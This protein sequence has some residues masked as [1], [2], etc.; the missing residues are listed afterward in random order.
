MNLKRK[1]LEE[2]KP[3]KFLKQSDMTLE[4]SHTISQFSF[5]DDDCIPSLDVSICTV[6]DSELSVQDFLQIQP[7]VDFILESSS[8]SLEE[9]SNSLLQELLKS[10]EIVKVI[11]DGNCFFRA[12]LK[13]TDNNESEHLYLRKSVTNFMKRNSFLF[14]TEY[15]TN[16]YIIEYSNRLNDEGI[17]ADSLIIHAT[18]LYLETCIEIYIPGYSKPI[19]VN[20]DSCSTIFLLNSDRNHFEVLMSKHFDD[21]EEKLVIDLKSLED[22]QLKKKFLMKKNENIMLDITKVCPNSFKF[23]TNGKSIYQSIYDY[24]CFGTLPIEIENIP[25]TERTKGGRIKRTQ[26]ISNFTKIC[27]RYCI[28]TNRENEFSMSRLIFFAEKGGCRYTIPYDDEI[29][30]LIHHFHRATSNHYPSNITKA[31]IKDA[32][33]FW[34]GMNERICKELLTCACKLIYPNKSTSKVVNK[35]QR[36]TSQ[37]PYERFQTDTADLSNEIQS[38]IISGKVLGWTTNCVLLMVK[39]HFAKYL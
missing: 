21:N 19:K 31:K 30:L 13:A 10:F 12:V 35:Y 32:G 25:R 20:E 14:Q 29:K 1:R 7:E 38:G 24:S 23:P 18:S 2:S 28:A 5:T 17:W 27:R 22:I 3:E 11:G 9:Q 26:T 34:I 37:A 8:K 33:I 39:D 36:I 4:R 15:V 16:E 6:T